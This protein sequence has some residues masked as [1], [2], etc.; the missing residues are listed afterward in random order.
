MQHSRCATGA[1]VH[2]AGR[3][4]SAGCPRRIRG[5]S[6]AESAA[7]SAPPRRLDQQQVRRPPRS[8]HGYGRLSRAEERQNRIRGLAL[9]P[10]GCGGGAEGT[11]FLYGYG[12]ICGGK[13]DE[14][15]VV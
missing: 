12:E 13:I 3:R 1:G 7:G 10:L 8:E 5:V 11:L 2:K 6:V 9:D 4:L 15:E 14:C